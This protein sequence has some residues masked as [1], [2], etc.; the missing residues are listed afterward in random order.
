MANV[1]YSTQVYRLD[2]AEVIRQVEEHVNE[3]RNT[4]PPT[5]TSLEE[6]YPASTI[7]LA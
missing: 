6:P 7:S 4:P 5:I 2:W 3:L 1:I